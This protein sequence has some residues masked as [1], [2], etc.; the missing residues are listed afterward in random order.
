MQLLGDNIIASVLRFAVFLFF[1]ILLGRLVLDWVQAFARDWRPRGPLLVVAEFIY[2]ITD[3][4][5]KALRRVIPPLT[6]G[7]LRL[8]LAFLV[9]MVGTSLLMTIL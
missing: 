2:T 8:D 6:L 7:T 9:L 5:L 4:P 1:V 3:P